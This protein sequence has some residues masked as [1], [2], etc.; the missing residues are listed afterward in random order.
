MSN[1]NLISAIDIKVFI[2]DKQIVFTKLELSDNNIATITMCGLEKFSDEQ[3]VTIF[4]GKELYYRGVI[5]SID[6][7]VE[8]DDVP[9]TTITTRRQNK[10]IS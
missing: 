1:Y 2:D 8:I 6:V 7:F 10:I 4:R 3:I 5:E 9:I